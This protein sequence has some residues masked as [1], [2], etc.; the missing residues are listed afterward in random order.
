MKN[1]NKLALELLLILFLLF[2]CSNEQEQNVGKLKVGVDFWI[3][4]T[5]EITGIDISHH[6]G[7][8]DWSEV[9]KQGVSFVFVKATEGIDY[10]DTMFAKYWAELEKENII[11]GAYHFYSSDDDPLE[12]AKWFV[13]KIKNFE[14]ILPPVLDVERKGHKNITKE[15]FEKSVLKCLEE[16]ERLSGKKPIIYSSPKFANSYLFDKRFDKYFLWVAEYGVEEPVIPDVW[17]TAGWHF[18]QNTSSDKIPGINT[19]VDHSKFSKKI[20]HLIKL[21]RD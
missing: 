15:S 19:A 9:K 2:C 11:R 12:Q 14:D 4:D 21:V 7:E 3:G 10:L 6:Q 1:K 18:W 20:E 5:T 16:I 17:R 8:I 13:G